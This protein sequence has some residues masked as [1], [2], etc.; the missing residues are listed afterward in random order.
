MLDLLRWVATG[1]D[2]IASPVTAA[3]TWANAAQITNDNLLAKP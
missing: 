2:P 3:Q 1:A